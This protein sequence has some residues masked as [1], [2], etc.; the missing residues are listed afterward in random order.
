MNIRKY[1]PE[2][3]NE[4]FE[5]FYNTVHT[6]NLK[7]YSREQVD[8]WA[9]GDVDARQW[10]KS[11]LRHYSIVAEQDGVI[12]GFGDIDDGGYLSMLYVH[13]DHQGIGVATAILDELEKYAKDK[14]AKEITTHA[15]ITS[16][17]VFEKRG[18]AV[19]SE[20]TVERKGQR[21][22]NYHMTKIFS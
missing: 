20:Q 13:K 2:D 4:V 12:T 3:C 9:P 17:P 11:R 15:S 7:D 10:G 5:L 14:N 16:R 1:R 21:L 6:V 19:V 22:T 8:A 18:Y